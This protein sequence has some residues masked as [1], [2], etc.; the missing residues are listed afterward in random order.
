MLSGVYNWIG[1]GVGS[2][3]VLLAGLAL[4][5]E[6]QQRPIDAGSV[7]FAI[8]FAA[9]W[10]VIAAACGYTLLHTRGQAVS[11]GCLF[12]VLVVGGLLLL[13][14]VVLLVPAIREAQDASG[15]EIGIFLGLGALFA[16]PSALLIWH[17]RNPSPE[18]HLV[19]LWQG[20]VVGVLTIFLAGA[21]LLATT[22]DP[23]DIGRGPHL[24]LAGVMALGA[25]A[26]VACGVA[27]WRLGPSALTGD[28]SG[29]HRRSR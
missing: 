20:V 29:P 21:V 27:L 8:V 3:C 2:L 6:L 19:R 10:G 12:I 24:V 25:V 9:F 22:G 5:S 13:T 1:L 23:Y 11:S 15:L 26:I 4:V 14:G 17:R 7:G 16:V 28:T 18:A